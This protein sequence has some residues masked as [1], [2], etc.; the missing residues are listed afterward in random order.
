V[1]T[2]ALDADFAISAALLAA[3]LAT[4]HA[5]VHV[6][7]PWVPS[8]GIEAS[9]HFDGLNRLFLL[10]ITGIGTLVFFYAPGYLH[11]HRDLGRLMAL[12]T[13][14]MLAMIGAVSADGM[15]LLFVFWEATSVLSFL[16]VGFG[17]DRKRAATASP[18][19][20]VTGAGAWPA[21]RHPSYTD[22]RPRAATQRLAR[23][24]PGL[25]NDPRSSSVCCSSSSAA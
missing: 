9:F 17:H 8:L 13:A 19:P 14:F 24:R 18:G 25:R 16:L 22:G 5:P 10:L 7:W 20:L 12:L 6:A 4:P 1:A 15:L 2:I 23:P 11:G 21:R 3:V